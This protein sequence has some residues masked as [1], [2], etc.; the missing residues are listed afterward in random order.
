M[1]CASRIVICSVLWACGLVSASARGSS[2][3]SGALLIEYFDG[4]NSS[5]GSW[6]GTFGVDGSRE[7]SGVVS[8]SGASHLLVARGV[9]LVETQSG[10]QAEDA[11]TWG[12]GTFSLLRLGPH[13]GPIT[14][15]VEAGPGV[16]YTSGAFPP[17][18]THW[19]FTQRYGFGVSVR[20]SRGFRLGISS[21][22]F[23]VSNGK[24][25]GDSRNPSFDGTGVV[26]E[27]RR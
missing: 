10:T 21:R 12:L 16:L 7:W 4:E 11:D 8:L 15:F 23:H 27:L 19:N 26:I 25:A 24:G 5:A 20:L 1:G 9:R 2:L 13:L 6:A 17:G 3:R 14:P 22:H 18:G